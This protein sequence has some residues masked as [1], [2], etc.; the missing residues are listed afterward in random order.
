MTDLKRKHYAIFSI[1]LFLAPLILS[2]VV[3]DVQ[4]LDQP[5]L[6]VAVSVPS[7]AGIAQEVGGLHVNTSALLNQEAEPHAFSLTP[8]VIAKADAA[9]LL[10]LTGHFTWEEELANLTAT[11]FITLHSEDALESYEDYGAALSPMPGQESGAGGS[12]HNEGNLH[13]FWLLPRNAVAIAN[14]TRA[15]LTTLNSTLS[16]EW[17]SNFNSFVDKMGE[18]QNTIE[19]LDAIYG[20]SGMHAVTVFPAEAYVAETFG[21]KVD[22]VL[23]IEDITLSGTKLLDIQ[24]AIRNGSISLI[25]GSDVAQFQAGGEFAY[26]LQADYGGTLIWWRTVFYAESEYFWMM[27]YNLGALV[28]GLIGRSGA[29]SDNTINIGLVALSCVLGVL[30]AIETVLIVMRAKTD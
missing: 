11:P 27:N 2:S 30:V 29:M 22:A 4:A 24:N 12:D 15:A 25:L 23:Q 9:D 17:D 1:A 3:I 18:L 5:I 21:I 28:S 20:F 8:E 16:D 14:A 26:Q 7:L 19:T 6:S 13:G 10:V